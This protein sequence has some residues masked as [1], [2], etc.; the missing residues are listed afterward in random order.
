RDTADDDAVRAEAHLVKEPGAT[1]GTEH[2][3][4]RVRAA[5]DFRFHA[6]DHRIVLF[7]DVAEVGKLFG[8]L[9]DEFDGRLDIAGTA[10]GL[11]KHWPFR[12]PA[13]R[14]IVFPEVVQIGR[15][16]V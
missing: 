5:G 11:N 2:T 3:L 4:D 16:H 14:A 1:A 9:D 13:E 12:C 10:R 8:Q 7:L 15:A 6:G